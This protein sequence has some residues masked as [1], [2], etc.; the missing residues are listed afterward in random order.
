[1]KDGVILPKHQQLGGR[2]R[3]CEKSFEADFSKSTG[4][5]GAGSHISESLRYERETSHSR[6][7][8]ND[9]GSAEAANKAFTA[10]RHFSRSTF[11]MGAASLT[12]QQTCCDI[13]DTESV[14]GRLPAEGKDV[15]EFVEGGNVTTERPTM[16]ERMTIAPER[17]CRV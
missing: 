5:H 11:L 17:G 14:P 16:V 6:E 7:P 15:S 1:M 10:N 9:N 3:D 12:P 2:L 13:Y 4:H 8:S